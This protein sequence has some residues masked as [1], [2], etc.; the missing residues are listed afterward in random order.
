MSFRKE[1]KLKIDTS[2]INDFRDYILK[3]N[4]IEEY[5]ERLIE[6]IYFDNFNYEMFKD[7]LEGTV[8]RKKI[9]LRSYNKKKNYFLEEKI[10]SLENRFKKSI[11]INNFEE[12]FKK[13]IL[14]KSYG[15]CRSVLIVSYIRKYY[16]SGPFRVTIDKNIEFTKFNSFSSALNR[17]KDSAIA[18]EVKCPIQISNEK[19]Y[20]MFP[21]EQIRF[22]KYSE[23]MEKLKII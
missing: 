16:K 21:F 14:D 15:I 4:F 17:Y 8:P 10:S 1:I 3:K 13:G 20:K 7:S 19:I 5:P 23:A 9:R 22:S 6:S 11:V 2:K 12:L 18:V